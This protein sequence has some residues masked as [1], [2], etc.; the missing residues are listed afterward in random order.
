MA[1]SSA[2]TKTRAA[3]PQWLACKIRPE[4]QQFQD[5]HPLWPREKW[6]VLT[7]QEICH[8][9]HR[10]LTDKITRNDQKIAESEKDP[11]GRI[12]MFD[13]GSDKYP[14]SL[15]DY[16]KRVVQYTRSVC[17]PV[18]QVGCVLLI[19]RLERAGFLLTSRNVY[20]V[21]AICY[22]I[23]Y[24]VIEDE[25]HIAN[26]KIAQI[27]GM[28]TSEL[29]ALETAL[30]KCVEFNLGMQ[31]DLDLQR[32]IVDMLLPPH[33]ISID[34][35]GIF[36]RQTQQYARTPSPNWTATTLSIATED[37]QQVYQ[38]RQEQLSRLQQS[39]QLQEQQQ[40]QQQHQQRQQQQDGRLSGATS[41]ES[42]CSSRGETPPPAAPEG[43]SDSDDEEVGAIPS[44]DSNGSL[45]CTCDKA[46]N[47]VV[48]AV[49]GEFRPLSRAEN[50]TSALVCPC[51]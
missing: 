9:M 18:V 22:F 36:Y 24:K 11:N 14:I 10:Y 39:I 8:N 33:E 29:V 2:A 19:E 12:M 23:A 6:S 46:F 47:N 50:Q 7:S 1:C 5:G 34:E 4:V 16:M 44:S 43:E 20:R 26:T 51:P 41:I 49:E 38:E 28:P 48:V 27:A 35:A 32:A 13:S 15:L 37:Q 21:F 31:H 45:S 30:C 40:Q 3:D 25:P 17:S 42:P